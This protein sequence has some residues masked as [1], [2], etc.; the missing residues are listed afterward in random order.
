M[1]VILL[2]DVKGVGKRFEEKNVAD[3][4]ANNILLPKGLA[5]AADK[6][7][8][9]RAKQMKEQSEAKHAREEAEKEA[10]EAKRLE[11]HRALEAFKL[12]QRK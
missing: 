10:K 12:S 1:K 5:L 3:G 8:L 11:K 7:G 4:Y 2:R 6:A 9:A